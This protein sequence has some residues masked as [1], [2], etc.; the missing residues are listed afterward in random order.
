MQLWSD[1]TA[2]T[3]EDG[4]ARAEP[5]HVYAVLVAVDHTAAVKLFQR[6]E[7]AL[8]CI[9]AEADNV[10]KEAEGPLRDRPLEDRAEAAVEGDDDLTGL[11]LRYVRVG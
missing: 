1:T 8:R 2:T 5:G 6:R 11:A 7:D 3:I 10:L 9:T 4:P